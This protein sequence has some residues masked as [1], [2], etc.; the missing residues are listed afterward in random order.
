MA[1]K[2]LIMLWS[3]YNIIPQWI[4]EIIFVLS[5]VLCEDKNTDIYLASTV[6]ISFSSL[7]C[8]DT[9]FF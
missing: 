7:L 8:T 5:H 1:A 2:C 4:P 3:V 6:L 9:D